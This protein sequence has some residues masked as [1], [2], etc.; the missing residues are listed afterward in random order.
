MNRLSTES[1]IEGASVDG[2]TA[3]AEWSNYKLQMDMDG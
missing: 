1:S 3:G 2:M